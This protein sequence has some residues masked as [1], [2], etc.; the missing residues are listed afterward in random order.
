M[1]FDYL[2]K[3]SLR[4]YGRKYFQVICLIR[5]RLRIRRCFSSKDR[6]TSSLVKVGQ[7]LDMCLRGRVG[8]KAQGKMLHVASHQRNAVK[9]TGSPQFP[10]V[11]VAPSQGP[12][13][14]C[15]RGQGREP[16]QPLRDPKFNSRPARCSAVGASSCT[17]RSRLWLESRSGHIPRFRVGSSGGCAQEATISVFLSLT[18]TLSKSANIASDED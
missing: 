2:M 11:R 6:Q 9:A 10:P 13:S 8:A 7:G 4:G 15:W 12:A 17:T 14:Q 18:L 16:L 5:F 1:C 3:T